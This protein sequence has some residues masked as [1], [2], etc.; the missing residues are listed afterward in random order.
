[1]RTVKPAIKVEDENLK[2][3][4]IHPPE[5]EDELFITKLPVRGPYQFFEFNGMQLIVAT[6]FLEIP[7]VN[8]LSID[9]FKNL[10]DKEIWINPFNEE[11][12]LTDIANINPLDDESILS[13]CNRY[14][15]YGQSVIKNEFPPLTANPLKVEIKEDVL[16]NTY[17]TLDY[18]VENTNLIQLILEIFYTEIPLLEDAFRKTNDSKLLDELNE[19]DRAGTRLIN[20]GLRL[21]SPQINSGKNREKLPSHRSVSLLGAAY[22]HLYEA[23]TKGKQF[24]NCLKCGSLF[25]PRTNN[26]AFCPPLHFGK[27]S[28]CQN[29]YNQMKNRARKDVKSGKK[30]IEEVAASL[31]RPLNE[32]RGWF[33]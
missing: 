28:S 16:I 21:V 15:L 23:V 12:L 31:G 8:E 4:I 7:N 30:T 27:H 26:A 24:R 20:R 6:G 11:N 17:E 1:M 18:F 32:V 25:I 14:G 3:K 9:E 33:N 29:S 2:K 10:F 22:Y 19:L 13:F 5:K